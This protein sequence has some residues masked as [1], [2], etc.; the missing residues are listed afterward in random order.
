MS[1]PPSDN[2]YQPP[3]ANIISDQPQLPYE[4]AGR[5]TK[6]L[7][8]LIDAFIGIVCSL[9]LWLLVDDFRNIFSGQQPSIMTLALGMV[10]GLV[11]FILVHGYYLNKYGQ[12]VGKR[13]LGVYIAKHDSTH[14]ADIKDILIKRVLPVTVAA[15]IPVVGNFLSLIDALFIFRADRRCIHDH[16]ASTHVLKM[17]K[18]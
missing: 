18:A 7:A 13:I 16:I 5:G 1:A 11:W 12:T 6:L 8:A 17:K 4:R 3:N 2:P 14:K 10:Y 15:L 9:P